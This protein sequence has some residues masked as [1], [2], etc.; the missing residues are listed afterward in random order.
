MLGAEPSDKAEKDDPTLLSSPFKRELDAY[1]VGETERDPR[2]GRRKDD[3]RGLW[4]LVLLTSLS[5]EER[6]PVADTR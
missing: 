6:L 5:R 4:P 2:K 1:P 3:R